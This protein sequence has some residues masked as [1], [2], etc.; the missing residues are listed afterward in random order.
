MKS[1]ERKVKKRKRIVHNKNE[2]EREIESAEKERKLARKRK[3]DRMGEGADEGA[4][5]EDR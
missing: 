1:G 2:E 5:I 3:K 4:V